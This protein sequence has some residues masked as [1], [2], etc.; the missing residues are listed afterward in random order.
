MNQTALSYRYDGTFDGLM[1][2]VFESYMKKELPTEILGP[3]AVEENLFGAKDILT[4][5]ANAQRVLRSIPA[6]I[7]HE[8]YD[9]VQLAFLSC[10]P[11]KELAILSFLRQ[12][13][14]YGPRIM[15]FA[16]N[17]TLH[18]LTEAAKHLLKEAHLLKGFIRFSIHQNVLITTIGPKN[19]VLPFL[20][21]HFSERY[22]DEHFLIYDENHHMALAYRPYESAIIPMDEFRAAPPD[23]EEAAFRALWRTFYDAIEIKPRHNEKCR[24]TLMPKR[25]WKYMTEFAAST[26][27]VEKLTQHNTASRP[28]PPVPATGKRHSNPHGL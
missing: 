4:N 9:L 5:E 6:K 1:C 2:C 11:Q 7:G 18:R 13:Y 19:F 27:G 17:E 23:K 14:H 28:H 24:Q 3:D 8:A 20:A 16:G 21:R 25:Y 15:G 10:L 26:E 12:G 22:P